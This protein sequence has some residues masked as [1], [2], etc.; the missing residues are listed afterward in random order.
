MERFLVTH[1]L[2]SSW[3]YAISDDPYS[4]ATNEKDPLADFLT[5]LRRE[6]TETTEA[7]LNGIDFENL[8]TA[9]AD[10]EETFG[11]IPVDPKEPSE[12]WVPMDIREHIWYNGAKQIA[13][14]VQNGVFQ[15]VAKRDAFIGGRNVLLYGRL[16]ALKAGHIYDIKFSRRY[17]VGKFYDSTQHPMYLN[18]VPEA[19]DFTYLVFNGSS[20]WQE[21]YSRKDTMPI[22]PVVEH[23]FEWLRG[24][25]LDD[26]YRENWGAK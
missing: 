14:I 1:S 6:P 13:D 18:L 17:E 11:F 5:V 23:F 7:M 2:L 22:E 26:L 9:I 15:Y 20:V 25:G 3:L 16:D 21:R 24:Q 19:L 8:V 10:G 4:D 12:G